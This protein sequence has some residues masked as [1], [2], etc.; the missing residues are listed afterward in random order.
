[1]TI[2]DL[3]MHIIRSSRLRNYW[4]GHDGIVVWPWTAHFRYTVYQSASNTVGYTTLPSSFSIFKLLAIDGDD[5][6]SF[7]SSFPSSILLLR[8]Q[9]IFWSWIR[10][11]IQQHQ[12]NCQS[13]AII[14]DGIVKRGSVL[15]FFR[16]YHYLSKKYRCENNNC[17]RT[18]NCR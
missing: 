8:H 12:T 7:N 2:F 3:R 5:D 18:T 16:A 6:D 15:W 1:M 11:R 9:F 17:W 4:L 13:L 14:L 10:A